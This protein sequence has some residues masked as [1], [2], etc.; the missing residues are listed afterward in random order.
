MGSRPVLSPDLTPSPSPARTAQSRTQPASPARGTTTPY[1]RRDAP[2]GRLYKCARGL[3]ARAHQARETP[4]EKLEQKIKD[5]AYLKYNTFDKE[6][7]KRYKP[8][9]FQADRFGYQAQKDEFICPAD[10]RLIYVETKA[11]E[12][13]NGYWSERRRYECEGCGGCSLKKKC[14]RAKGNR[15]I[16]VSFKL[17]QMRVRARSDL[18]SEEGIALRRRRGVDVESVFGRIKQNWK[19]WGFLLRGLEKVEI[20]WGLLCMA[21]KMAK[22]A[23][24]TPPVSPFFA[25]VPAGIYG[26]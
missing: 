17:Q 25:P 3:E 22:L 1:C 2:P 21:H 15:R 7:R 16:T 8:D 20:E 6:Q 14:T 18:T 5:R 24:W 12:T 4:A 13:D 26:L 11:C 23:V 10:R 19:S 9:P